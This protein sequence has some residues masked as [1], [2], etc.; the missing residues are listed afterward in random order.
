MVDNEESDEPE[1]LLA[2]YNGNHSESCIPN[3]AQLEVKA[4]KAAIKKTI[5]SDPTLKPTVVYN[6]EVDRVVPP[7]VHDVWTL[8]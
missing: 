1:F 5:L 8:G 2:K 6:R 3:S 4:V 7:A